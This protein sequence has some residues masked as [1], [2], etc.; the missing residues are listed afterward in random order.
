MGLTPAQL[1]AKP[2]EQLCVAQHGA[3]AQHALALASSA[4]LSPA[5][6][7]LVADVECAVLIDE[8]LLGAR[9]DAV[10]D[11]PTR[12][13]AVRHATQDLGG[14]APVGL[15]AVRAGGVVAGLQA[16]R[17]ASER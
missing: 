1:G 9:D 16:R 15:P 8:A 12:D 13:A 7:E 10:G 4:H 2:V 6:T 14:G 17:R 11:G 3:T 5:R